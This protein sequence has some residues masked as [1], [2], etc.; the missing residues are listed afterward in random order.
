MTAENGGRP[1]PHVTWDAETTR[2][3]GAPRGA[4][5][6]GR[7]AEAGQVPGQARIHSSQESARGGRGGGVVS[8]GAGKGAPDASVRQRRRD[9]TTP[10][11]R[12]ASTGSRPRGTDRD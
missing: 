9:R 5:L 1:Q 3:A 4:R 6:Q 8:G 2:R 12:Q 7:A 10:R 11:P